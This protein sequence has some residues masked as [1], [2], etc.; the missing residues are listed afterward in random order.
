MRKRRGDLPLDDAAANSERAVAELRQAL[1]GSTSG[2]PGHALERPDRRPQR[3]VLGAILERG[4]EPAGSLGHRLA[5]PAGAVARGECRALE[6]IHHL[7]FEK[8]ARDAD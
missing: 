6:S 2:V 7:A 8:V 3:I 1:A 5:N 4:E